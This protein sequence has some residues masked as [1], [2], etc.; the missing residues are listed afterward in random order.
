MGDG[1]TAKIYQ[2]GPAVYQSFGGGFVNN[3][4]GS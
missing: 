4:Q 1:N 2:R 3:G